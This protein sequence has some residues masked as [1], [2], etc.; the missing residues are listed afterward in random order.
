M[1]GGANW[2]DMVRAAIAH[3]Y[4]AATQTETYL[5]L[6]CVVAKEM[7]GAESI[8]RLRPALK[9]RFVS[10]CEDVSRYALPDL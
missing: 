6:P 3:R 9:M 2:R 10:E 1:A 4:R 8:A 5:D 7:C